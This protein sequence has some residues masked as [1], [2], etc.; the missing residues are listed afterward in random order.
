MAEDGCLV[1]CAGAAQPAGLKI[2]KKITKIPSDVNPSKS[3][4][5]R[6]A[7]LLDRALAPF[8]PTSARAL[9]DHMAKNVIYHQVGDVLALEKPYGGF[10]VGN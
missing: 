1:K 9:A 7:C 10:C 3:T 5:P 4:S 8:V 2:V 6:V